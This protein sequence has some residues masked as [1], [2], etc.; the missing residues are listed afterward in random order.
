VNKDL[1]I[2]LKIAAEIDFSRYSAH[3]TPHEKHI[4]ATD[5]NKRVV[6]KI[7]R[8]AHPGRDRNAIV[9]LYYMHPDLKVESLC[10]N[11]MTCFNDTSGIVSSQR[12][13]ENKNGEW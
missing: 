7:K 6:T 8:R 5:F 2:G 4:L 13:E 11:A 3:K 1:I 12:Q 10:S 9:H